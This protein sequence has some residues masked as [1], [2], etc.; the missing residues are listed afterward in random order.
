MAF[1]KVDESLVTSDKT[2][3]V[4]SSLHYYVQKQVQLVS[5]IDE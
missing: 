1:R 4:S 5:S 3:K 2:W